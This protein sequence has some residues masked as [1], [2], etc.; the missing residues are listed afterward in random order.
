MIEFGPLA[1]LIDP[2][3]DGGHVVIDGFLA[4][5][6]IEYWRALASQK[7]A[8]GVLRPAAVGKG[9]RRVV[10]GAV[11]NDWIS[12]I[13]PDP[14]HAIEGRLAEKLEGLRRTLNERFLL[15]LFD[16]ELHLAVYPPGG[17]YRA[18]VDRFEDDDHRIV[19]MI[20]YLN[21]DWSAQ[22]GGMLRIWRPADADE[23]SFVDIAPI[24]GRLVLF[25]SAAT[26]HEVLPTTQSRCALTGWFRRRD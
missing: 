9:I 25:P 24:A 14:H 4:A 6:E 10:A 22:S 20:L 11:R 19:S 7:S 18:H 13:E 12:W 21:D 17:F 26:R 23:S 8:S 15:G 1:P 2:L 16:L 3:G 5:A